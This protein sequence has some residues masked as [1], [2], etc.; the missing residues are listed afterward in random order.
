MS[1]GTAEME[2]GDDRNPDVSV[3]RL[4]EMFDQPSAEEPTYVSDVRGAA[5]GEYVLMPLDVDRRSGR[6]PMHVGRAM[7]R[8]AHIRPAVSPPDIHR[9]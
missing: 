3:E 4:H 9:G 2:R 1:A 6:L 8:R 5:I 7:V